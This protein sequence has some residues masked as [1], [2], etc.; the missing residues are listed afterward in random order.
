MSKLRDFLRFFPCSFDFDPLLPPQEKKLSQ[1][2]QSIGIQ[3][4][5]IELYFLGLGSLDPIIMEPNS[6]L[7]LPSPP[8]ISHPP[9][10]TVIII[11]HDFMKTF[12][13]LINP[14][15]FFRFTTYR[16]VMKSYYASSALPF[17]VVKPFFSLVGM[18][19]KKR[20]KKRPI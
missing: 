19:P 7:L 15:F 17:F 9:S 2:G 6:W 16:E 11:I 13:M 4:H 5:T 10:L 18:P 1:T 14:F 20:K 8:H 3:R 12:A